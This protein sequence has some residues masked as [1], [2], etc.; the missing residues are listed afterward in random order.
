MYN[1]YALEIC[2]KYNRLLMFPKKK[3]ANNE[4]KLSYNQQPAINDLCT[5]N[6]CTYIHTTIMANNT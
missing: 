6:V 2:K 4:R 3:Q 1:I 5:D